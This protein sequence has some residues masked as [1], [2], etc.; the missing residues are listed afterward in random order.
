MTINSA[1]Q[2][3]VAFAGKPMKWGNIGLGLYHKLEDKATRVLATTKRL[4]CS[5]GE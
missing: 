2:R 5:G 1:H 3:L 4:R